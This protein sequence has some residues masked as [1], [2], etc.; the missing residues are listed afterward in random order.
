C[1]AGRGPPHTWSRVGAVWWW[2]GCRSGGC[3]GDSAF[4]S[5]FVVACRAGGESVLVQPG[6]QNLVGML[7]GLR[8]GQ[9]HVVARPR[10]GY[11]GG[12]S[13]QAAGPPGNVGDVQDRVGAVA[14]LRVDTGQVGAV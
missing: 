9:E 3:R 2:E 5:G 12:F 7:P 8:E 4:R 10:N 1:G 13:A 11:Y 14:Q 6:P